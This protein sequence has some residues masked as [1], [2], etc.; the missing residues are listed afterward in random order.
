MGRGD[1]DRRAIS[2][3]GL[4]GTA[5]ELGRGRMRANATRRIPYAAKIPNAREASDAQI[6]ITKFNKSAM[7]PPN[8]SIVWTP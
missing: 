1:Q 3:A 5:C 7:S 4:T 6:S 8:G 2:G